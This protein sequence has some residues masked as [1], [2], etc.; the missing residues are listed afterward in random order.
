MPLELTSLI[1]H[2]DSAGTWRDE[3]RKAFHAIETYPVTIDSNE[4]SNTH[5]HFSPGNGQHWEVPELREIC[6]AISYFEGAFL[7]LVPQCQ[8]SNPWSKTIGAYNDKLGPG[9]TPRDRW[10]TIEKLTTVPDIVE[11]MCPND[12]RMFAW[13]FTNLWKHY[14]THYTG[15]TIEWRL[16]PGVK[17]AEGC[18]MWAEL[19]LNFVQAARQP[20]THERLKKEKPT[21][22]DLKDFVYEQDGKTN[23]ASK[24]AYLEPVFNNR[25]GRCEP[26][27]AREKYPGTEKYPDD[28]DQLAMLQKLRKSDNRWGHVTEEGPAF[29]PPG[30]GPR[31]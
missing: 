11:F 16:A 5:V 23:G 10:N 8:R 9:T 1:L 22:Q 3:V 24:L 25:T 28:L 21:V 27:K 15:W 31:P 7:A 20:G 30:A 6:Y 12:D 18:L 4:S 17:T 13:N 2:F 19:A 14:E 26:R 29:Q